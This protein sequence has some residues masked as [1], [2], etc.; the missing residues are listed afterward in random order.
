[1]GGGMMKPQCCWECKHFTYCPATP[2]YSE[3]TPG[4]NFDIWCNK[5]I[6]KFDAYI[7]TQKEFEK[8][9][10]TAKTCDKFEERKNA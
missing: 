10:Q 8:I 1:M 4:S 6:W 2:D 9:L 3:Y 5:N 7:T